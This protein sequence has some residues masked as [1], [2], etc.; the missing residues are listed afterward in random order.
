MAENILHFGAITVRVNGTG[1]LRMKLKSLDDVKTKVIAP[2]TMSSTP[3]K[4]P[5]KLTNFNS[6]RA[7]YRLETTAIDEYMKI[8]RIVV[9]IKEIY[10]Q[11]PSA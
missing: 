2:I 9:W 10:T 1:L 8:N 11:F 7:R 6:Q 5:T 4:E 3:G